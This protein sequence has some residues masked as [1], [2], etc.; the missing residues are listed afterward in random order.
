MKKVNE[1]LILVVVDDSLVPPKQITIY[2]QFKTVL[3]LVVVDD[4][5]VLSLND[6]LKEWNE[7]S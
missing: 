2:S 3:I 5:L 7:A 6:K 1:V 4:S